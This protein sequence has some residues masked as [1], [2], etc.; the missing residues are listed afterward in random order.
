MLSTAESNK[1]QDRTLAFVVKYEL[2]SRTPNELKI[3]QL[4]SY[5]CKLEVLLQ[6][7]D[8]Y[9]EQTIHFY[10]EE[11][12][13]STGRLCIHETWSHVQCR[14]LLPR[15][16]VPFGLG[17]VSQLNRTYC[18]KLKPDNRTCKA[19]SAKYRTYIMACNITSSKEC[20][21]D[22]T[23]Y[24]SKLSPNEIAYYMSYH[25]FLLGQMGKTI[26]SI[27]C[28]EKALEWN[29]KF[30]DGDNPCLV[31]GRICRMMAKPREQC[32]STQLQKSI[33]EDV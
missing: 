26:E 29:G 8:P 30:T 16:E 4:N 15:K 6:W 23:S 28:L 5:G 33:S 14:H 13:D 12:W 20:T 1:I 10:V 7:C 11:I 25:G 3:K 31:E 27:E 17:Q 21:Q 24:R 9:Q 32:D 22:V 18:G 2:I 19:L